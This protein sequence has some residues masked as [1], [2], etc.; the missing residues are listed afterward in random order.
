[1]DNNS[2]KDDNMQNNINNT[3]I[4]NGMTNNNKITKMKYM[5]LQK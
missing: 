2:L 4:N 1:M 3:D 5:I